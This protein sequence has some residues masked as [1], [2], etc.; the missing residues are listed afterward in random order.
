V[1][2]RSLFTTGLIVEPLDEISLELARGLAEIRS[3]FGQFCTSRLGLSPEKVLD[4]C[5]YPERERLSQTLERYGHVVPDPAS[6]DSYREG[7]CR[8]WDRWFEEG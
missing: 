7:L 8:V 6:S 2:A 1:A 4:G 5:G 3:A